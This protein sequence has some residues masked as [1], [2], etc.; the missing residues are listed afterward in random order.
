[1]RCLLTVDSLWAGDVMELG[2]DQ[3]IQLHTRGLGARRRT[4]DIP[5]PEQAGVSD[6]WVVYIPTGRWAVKTPHRIC[7][8]EHPV[9]LYRG[10][11]V[12]QTRAALEDLWAPLP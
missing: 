10:P 4:F 7:P 2:P 8:L 6:N 3:L 1:M 9:D 11:S 5:V 12:H